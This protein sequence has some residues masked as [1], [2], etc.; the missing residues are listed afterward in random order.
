MDSCSPEDECEISSAAEVVVF[1]LFCWWQAAY[2]SAKVH[3]L[4]DWW[5]QHR[6]THTNEE[7]SRLLARILTVSVRLGHSSARVHRLLASPILQQRIERTMF[8]KVGLASPYGSEESI[9]S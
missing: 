2:P 6:G 1:D 9:F 5:A 4:A 3:D 7:F 8:L